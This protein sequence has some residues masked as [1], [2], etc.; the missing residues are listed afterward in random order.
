MLAN[1]LS[2]LFIYFH[3]DIP[4]DV[5]GEGGAGGGMGEADEKYLN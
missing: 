5:V 1:I 4:I 2:V 3:C